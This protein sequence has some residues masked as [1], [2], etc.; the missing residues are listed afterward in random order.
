MQLCM[1]KKESV[2]NHYKASSGIHSTETIFFLLLTDIKNKFIIFIILLVKYA[3]KYII[4]KYVYLCLHFA[5]ELE[6]YYLIMHV[7]SVCLKNTFVTCILY[8]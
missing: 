2:R 4:Y 8:F 7:F 5:S 3:C 6:Q 1:Q